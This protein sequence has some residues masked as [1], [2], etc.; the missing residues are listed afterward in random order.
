MLKV[1]FIAGGGFPTED[2]PFQGIFNQRAAIQLAEL[3]DLTVVQYRMYLPGRKLVSKENFGAYTKIT[4]CVPISPFFAI[5]LYNINNILFKLFTNFFIKEYLKKA[6]IV[7]CVDGDRGVLFSGVKKKY[8]F[9][10]L[11][12]FIGGDLNQDLPQQL[13]RGRLGNWVS[14]LDAVSFNSK[15]LYKKYKALFGTHK[16]MKVIYRGV[17]YCIFKPNTC[18]KKKEKEII[19]YFLGGVPNYKTFSKGRNTKG[20]ITLMDAWSIIDKKF[21]KFNICLKFAGPDSSIGFVQ[22][23]RLKLAQPSKVELLGMIHPKNIASFHRAGNVL[24]APSLEEGLPNTVMEACSTKNLVIAT[25]VGGIP[26][27]I[28]NNENGILIEPDN[29]AKLVEAISSI[30]LNRNTIEVLGSA[31]RKKMEKDFDSKNFGTSYYDL[32]KQMLTP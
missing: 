7:H 6:D 4:L 22:E 17:D 5:T 14:N 12:Q 1:V 27:I 25:N 23:W 30:I 18:Y 2:K 10:L 20:G 15:S 11:V 19:F 16:K 21:K 9:K 24:L 8:S 31:A 29:T 28:D 26:E 13:A 32:Y 3:V